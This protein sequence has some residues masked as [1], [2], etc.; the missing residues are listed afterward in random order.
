[1]QMA[2]Q[3]GLP[4]FTFVNKMDRVGADFDVDGFRHVARYN[5]EQGC[6][7]MFL[8]SVRE[9]QVSIAERVIDIGAGELLHTENSYKYHPQE[10]SDLADSSGF[11]VCRHWTDEQALF[12]L[13]LL[14]AR[15]PQEASSTS[16]SSK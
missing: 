8:E 2:E 11:E 12:S 3:F 7:Q 13:F 14:Q 6:I 1:M 15:A 10:F 4:I 5:E 16:R 9:Q